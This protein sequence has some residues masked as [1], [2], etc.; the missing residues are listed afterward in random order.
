[1]I[2]QTIGKV[3]TIHMPIP[4]TKM[5]DT[6]ADLAPIGILKGVLIGTDETLAGTLDDTNLKGIDTAT[7]GPPTDR[8]IGHQITERMIGKEATMIGRY[9]SPARRDSAKREAAA[10]TRDAA[11]SPKSNS[12]QTNED[13]DMDADQIAAMMGFQSFGSSKGKPV[14]ENAEG[15][16]E[17][18]KER[19]WRQYMNRRIQPAS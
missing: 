14:E 5:K 17:V 10:E 16:A 13:K 19:S 3:A 7:K 2:G 18:R 1:M 4:D 9:S 15:Y 6:L 12:T 11:P 8:K